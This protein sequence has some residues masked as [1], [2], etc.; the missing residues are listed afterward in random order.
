MIVRCRLAPIT[1]IL[2][3]FALTA[4]SAGA[5]TIVAAQAAA[6]IS[7]RLVRGM[8]PL[9]GCSLTFLVLFVGHVMADGATADRTENAMV[10]G[11]MAGHA[12]DQRALE[13]AFCFG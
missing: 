7:V 1:S 8:R 3:H 2:A 12:A 13:T 9:I 11:V 10:A 5:T 4:G 6:S